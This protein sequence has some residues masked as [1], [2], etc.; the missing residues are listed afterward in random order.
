MSLGHVVFPGN[1]TC[2]LCLALRR[3]S[4]V[5]VSPGPSPI[6]RE[7]CLREIQILQARLLD[8]RDLEIGQL[9][10]SAAAGAPPP[11]SAEGTEAKTEVPAAPGEGAKARTAESAESAKEEESQR[12]SES[13]PAEDRGREREKSKGERKKKKKSRSR[14]RRKKSRKAH[15]VSEPKEET[16]K[17]ERKEKEES[18]SSAEVKSPEVLVITKEELSPIELARGPVAEVEENSAA[19]PTILA[20]TP[21]IRPRPS[22][23]EASSSTRGPYRR[24]PLAEEIFGRLDRDTL[25]REPRRERPRSPSRSPPVADRERPR[26]RS[27]SRLRTYTAKGR[28]KR[29]RQQRIR[30]L[31]WDHF[32]A[33][34]G[35]R[36]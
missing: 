15:K 17:R 10:A 25:D 16:A 26:L 4:E 28:K 32:H 29:E 34:K 24:G 18:Q 13:S 20:S 23:A 2:S 3:I 9:R 5:V 8:W 31:G 6:F 22:E 27:R 11:A 12:K 33:T 30:D 36:Y 14:S 21:K 1:C 7:R 35:H 19:A